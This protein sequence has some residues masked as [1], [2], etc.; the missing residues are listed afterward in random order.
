MEWRSLS[1]LEVRS[2]FEL[3][4]GDGYRVVGPVA[5]GG[6][7]TLGEASEFDD[8]AVGLGLELAP[9]RARV[10]P[11]PAMFGAIGTPDSLKRWQH[12]PQRIIWKGERGPNGFTGSAVVEESAGP[13]AFFG[14]RACDLAGARVL[15]RAIRRSLGDRDLTIA[16]QCTAFAPTCFCTTMDTGPAVPEDAADL[17][18][19]EVPGQSFVIAAG[20]ELGA[21]VL[22]RLD[23]SPAPASLIAQASGLVEKVAAD[24]PKAFD[25]AEG[26]AALAQPG[27]G[28]DE[29]AER[30]LACGNCTAVCPTCFCVTVVDR[31]D[32]AASVAERVSLWDSCF[33][34]GFSEVHGGSVRSTTASRY[35]QWVSHKVSW[36]W[37]QWGTAGCVGCG[38]C[39]VWCP[40]GID[41]R[42]EVSSA[43]ER[44]AARV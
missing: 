4:R 30:C 40:V 3:L 2:L 24:M 32:P 25:P 27:G 21:S 5:A 19:T 41:I 13:V 28:W 37:D 33:T 36:W 42:Q 23:T 8:L 6:S 18:L 12:A 43:I 26:R 10:V 15:S 7:I 20:S 1:A 14:V 29:V 35:R 16:M 17:V 34:P 11:T 38:R 9:G 39:I 22:N 31:T 44:S